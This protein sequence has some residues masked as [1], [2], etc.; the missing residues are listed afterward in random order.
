MAD[1][2]AILRIPGF[3]VRK[4]SDLPKLKERAMG[5]VRQ[6]EKVNKHDKAREVEK[7]YRAVKEMVLQRAS[8]AGAQAFSKIM[9]AGASGIFRSELGAKFCKGEQAGKAQ[10]FRGSQLPRDGPPRWQ[11]KPVEKPAEKAAAKNPAEAH[12][13]KAQGTPAASA[14]PRKSREERLREKVEAR[15]AKA[16]EKGAESEKRAAAIREKLAAKRAKKNGE[17][18]SASGASPQESLPSNFGSPDSG[19]DAVAQ[20]EPTEEA[21]AEGEAAADDAAS[22]EAAAEGEAAGDDAASEEDNEAEDDAPA[23]DVDYF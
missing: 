21:A 16:S 14:G 2:F 9:A 13:L 12:F 15:R 7:A 3:T 5:L 22:E 10:Q 20:E 8:C 18:L 19:A 11:A 1:P 23:A 6:Y 17:E 4:E